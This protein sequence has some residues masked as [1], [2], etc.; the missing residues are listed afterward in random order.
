MNNKKITTALTL[1]LL[2]GSGVAGA[3]WGDVYY[4]VTKTAD[5]TDFYGGKTKSDLGNG[6]KFKLDKTRKGMVFSD[7]DIHE[8]DWDD[9]TP[10]GES[11]VG[12]TNLS[13][14]H[15]QRGLFISSFHSLFAVDVYTGTCDKF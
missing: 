2:L 10:I 3:E 9:D 6:F 11:W 15:F 12:K 1:L 4:C 5:K 7:D 14:F 8:I 13:F